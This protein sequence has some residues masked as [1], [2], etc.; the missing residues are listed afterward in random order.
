MVRDVTALYNLCLLLE[1]KEKIDNA[2]NDCIKE[3]I[4]ENK[5]GGKL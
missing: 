2:F 5:V 4:E 3:L 1:L